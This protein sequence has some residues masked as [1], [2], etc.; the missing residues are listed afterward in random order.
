M[1]M[2]KNKSF[3]L[4]KIYRLILDGGHTPVANALITDE[5]STVT[6]K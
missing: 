3:Y 1:V 2:V 6:G 5:H 4:K